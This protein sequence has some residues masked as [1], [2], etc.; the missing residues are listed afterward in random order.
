MEK[1]KE[2]L[3][4]KYKNNSV[5]INYDSSLDVLRD[6]AGFLKMLVLDYDGKEDI[7]NTCNKLFLMVVEEW[8]QA[9]LETD[10]NHLKQLSKSNQSSNSFI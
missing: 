2:M 1:I 6:I 4:S 3:E 5:N 7:K 9:G 8:K 10:L